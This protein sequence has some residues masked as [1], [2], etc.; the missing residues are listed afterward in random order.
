MTNYRHPLPRDELV[1]TEDC[2]GPQVT[3]RDGIEHSLISCTA[4]G[5]SAMVPL[6]RDWSEAP[7]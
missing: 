7:S 4:C 2:T 3:R 5:R 6:R 1:H